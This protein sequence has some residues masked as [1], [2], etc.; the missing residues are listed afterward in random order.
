MK[1]KFD[2]TQVWLNNIGQPQGVAGNETAD[3]VI[4]VSL[5]T[6]KSF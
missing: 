1:F 4:E 5:S 2:S 6:N 3:I